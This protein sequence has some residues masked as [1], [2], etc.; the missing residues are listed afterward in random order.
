MLILS[1]VLAFYFATV[2]G[3]SGLAKIEQPAAFASSLRKQRIFPRWSITSISFLIPWGEIVLAIM[4]V[5]RVNYVFTTAL[6]L[7]LFAGFLIIEA[8][9]L[10]T[11]RTA[12]CGCYGTVFTQKVDAGSLVTSFAFVCF[13]TLQL[14][15]ALTISPANWGW[16][17]VPA[18]VF[19]ITGWLLLQRTMR[20]RREYIRIRAS[21]RAHS[22]DAPILHSVSQT[23][24][25]HADIDAQM[26]GGQNGESPA[27]GM[28]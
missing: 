13:A 12:A 9:L 7:T 10:I 16:H 17:L 8:I 3:V 18:I 14:W 22:P 11:K 24:A 26:V 21:V 15:I 23:D 19:F 4:L 28:R 20:R 27:R 1:L 6:V 25:G 5:L 2:L